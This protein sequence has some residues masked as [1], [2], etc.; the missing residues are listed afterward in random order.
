MITNQCTPPASERVT[1]A[2]GRSMCS[3]LVVA[4]AILCS[5][6]DEQSD[7]DHT[8]VGRLYADEPGLTTTA[9]LERFGREMAAS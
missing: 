8:R 9:A 1:S 6:Y 3:H 4:E 2:D 7:G 5:R